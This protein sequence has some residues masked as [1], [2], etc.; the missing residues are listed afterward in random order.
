M[1]KHDIVTTFYG[2]DFRSQNPHEGSN[3]FSPW[4]GLV[5]IEQ[6]FIEATIVSHQR[7]SSSLTYVIQKGH[8]FQ[9]LSLTHILLDT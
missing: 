5:Y 7:F 8:I 6:V 2:D 4:N 1:D 9:K 3:D